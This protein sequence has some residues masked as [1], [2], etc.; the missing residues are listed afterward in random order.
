MVKQKRT[1]KP[2]RENKSRDAKNK[3]GDKKKGALIKVLRSSGNSDELA[4]KS[5][6]I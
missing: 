1:Q 5:D 2:D 4:K 6:K 3:H